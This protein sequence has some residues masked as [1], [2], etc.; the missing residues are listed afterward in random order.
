MDLTIGRSLIR[1]RD[2]ALVWWAGLISMTGNLAMFVALP[3][4]VHS[5]T[6]SPWAT[7]VTALAGL[8]PTLLLGQFAG[9]IVDRVDRRT[10]LIL[11]NLAMAVATCGFLLIP[12]GAWWPFAAV[13][14]IVRCLG[15]FAGPAEHALLGELIPPERLGEGASLNAMNNN[16]ARLIGPALGGLLYAGV[17]LH[18]TVALDAVSFLAAAILMILVARR[19]PYPPEPRTEPTGWLLDWRHGARMVWAHRE[20]R[21]LILLVAVTTFGEGA[22]SALLAPFTS[23]VLHGG[24]GVLGAMLSAQAIGG[25]AGAW[26]ASRVA[27]RRSPLSLLGGAALASGVLLAVIFNYA[28]VV[29]NAIPAVLLT[30][31]AGFPFAVFGAAQGYALQ[32]YA[33]PHLRGRVFALAAGILSLAQLAGIT[34]AGLAA[35]QWGSLVINIDAATY[36]IAGVIAIR[37]ARGRRV[38]ASPC[39]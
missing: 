23:D 4:A 3:V 20:L 38:T 39:P 33:P 11:A 5:R 16:V 19:R 15:Q 8:V 1:H 28:L 36:L 25:I 27:D 18:L 29:P 22:I 12:D 35:E 17:G 21:P 14:L 32:V 26:W 6:G 24:A 30:G 37:L 31:L 9:V 7:A 13:N 2:F 34:V 10:V